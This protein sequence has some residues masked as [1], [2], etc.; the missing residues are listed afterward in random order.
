MSSLVVSGLHKS[1]GDINALTGFS[2]QVNEGEFF[3][4][5]G[6][7]ASGK[8]TSFRCI[9]GIEKADAGSIQFQGQDITNAPIQG[10]GFAMV[11]QTFALY[12]HF[13]VYENLAYPLQE[14]GMDASAIRRRIG[15]VAEM[16]RL[17]HTLERKP[18]TCS[19]G[20]QQ[21]VAIGRALVRSP[22][23]LLLDEPLTNLDAK[24]RHDTRAE[25]KRIHREF[26]LTIIYATP[27]ELEALSMGQR[28][29]VLNA[30]AIEQVG[31][32]DEL[33][34]TPDNEFVAR[35]VGSPVIN[36]IDSRKSSD[37]AGVSLPFCD[38]P[39]ASK[40][41]ALNEFSS[42]DELRFAVRP[43]DLKLVKGDPQG[44][45]FNASIHLIEPLGDV[46]LF[47]INA[48]DN[49]LRMILPE[50]V[51]VQYQ[52]G[53]SLHIEFNPENCHL[54]AKDTGVAIG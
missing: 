6:P 46:T 47:D 52:T 4:L 26:G 3:A 20:E 29:G 25:F 36:F 32:P 49:T 21:R 40:Q 53:D 14:E 34:E 18:D 42:S 37:G 28:I 12:P 39:L 50:E 31:T 15:E 13:S 30:G 10:R 44:P 5:L 11:F 8:T 24:L 48:G 27:D 45:N 9:A 38:V 2:L 41:R 43:H 1:F 16:L 22:S 33:Y 51:A 19:G 54:F 7:S 17:S 35:M 23:L